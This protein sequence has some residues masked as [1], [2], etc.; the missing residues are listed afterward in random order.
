MAT[1]L[2]V[3]PLTLNM[4][5]IL[6]QRD[7]NLPLTITLDTVDASKK[8]ELSTDGGTLYFEPA[9][10]TSHANQL[11]VVIT[12][13]VTNVKLTGNIADTYTIL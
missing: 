5:E 6:S 9:Y 10:N 3:S 11:V 12:A 13:P 1:P 4:T 2:G 7:N 8:I